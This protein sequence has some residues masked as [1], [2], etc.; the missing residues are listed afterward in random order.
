MDPQFNAAP[1]PEYLQE[2][3]MEGKSSYEDLEVSS[4]KADGER[5]YRNWEEESGADVH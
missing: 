3:F 2:N 4:I 5:V 1:G